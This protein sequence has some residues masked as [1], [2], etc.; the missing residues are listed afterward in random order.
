MSDFREIQFRLRAGNKNCSIKVNNNIHDIVNA[1]K[2][3]DKDI[4]IN[5][6]YTNVERLP[7]E[8]VGDWFKIMDEI[9]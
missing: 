5:K 2:Q 8:T 7:E 4:R 1:I 9:S 6:W 3:L